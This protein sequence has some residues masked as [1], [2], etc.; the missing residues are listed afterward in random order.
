[1]GFSASSPQCLAEQLAILRMVPNVLVEEDERSA[2]RLTRGQMSHHNFLKLF[3]AE[4]APLTLMFPLASYLNNP[5][6]IQEHPILD[7][8]QVIIRTAKHSNVPHVIVKGN[9]KDRG[10][11]QTRFRA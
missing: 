9:A 11:N 4:S 3:L 5:K 10:I 8:V 2:I 6:D 1:M 7:K